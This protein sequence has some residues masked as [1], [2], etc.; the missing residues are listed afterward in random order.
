VGIDPLALRIEIAKR[1]A[2]KTLSFRVGGAEDLTAFANASLDVVYLSA[3]FHWLP[4]KLAPLREFLR[5]L[6]PGGRLG[7]STGARGSNSLR[8][9]RKQILARPEYSAQV[10]PNDDVGHNVTADELRELLTQ[11][12][13][14][15][16]KL[17]VVTNN[18]F[19]PTPSAAIDFA[20]ASSFGNFLG[21]VP[22][23][24]RPNARREIEAELE[25][26]RTADG[27]PTQG[28]RLVAIARKP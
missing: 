3:V 21:R 22:E 6:K 9:L 28:A 1:K 15:V 23:S 5:V 13:F 19:H 26:R 27:I 7:I 10:D 12:G 17:D 4:E 18:S 14:A 24:L 2:T 11:N 20:Q 8:Q 25:T 16:E